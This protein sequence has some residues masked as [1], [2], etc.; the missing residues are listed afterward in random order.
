MKRALFAALGVSLLLAACVDQNKQA[1]RW[2]LPPITAASDPEALEYRRAQARVFESSD[3]AVLIEAA[4]KALE[5][6]GFSVDRK[7]A[8]V[9]ILSANGWIPDSP[10]RPASPASEAGDVFLRGLGITVSLAAALLLRNPAALSG[11]GLSLG[12]GGGAP[13]K[14]MGYATVVATANPAA[15]TTEVRIWYDVGWVSPTKP[16]TYTEIFISMSDSTGIR[17]K[18]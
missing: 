13:A 1:E 14:H 16:E 7:A 18:T 15:G 12:G 2:T 17:V 8:S 4:A 10:A 5:V 11:G 6:R 3:S 9:G